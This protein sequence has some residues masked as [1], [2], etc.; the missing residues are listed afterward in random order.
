MLDGLIIRVG[1]SRTA[2]K[3]E[4]LQTKCPHFSKNLNRSVNLLTSPL[5]STSKSFSS[6]PS[7][8]KVNFK[9]EPKDSSLNI[10]FDSKNVLNPSGIVLIEFPILKCGCVLSVL[11]N[12]L[13]SNIITPGLT[14]GWLILKV[15]KHNVNAYV[16]N[17]IIN[18]S[19]LFK[20]FS[21][22][23]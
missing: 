5:P 22:L 3:S 21:F 11:N 18:N 16:H 2:L 17:I 7:S 15:K 10:S 20:S 12:L 23:K 14:N 6:S 4:T 19:H 1:S 8:L 9:L 13:P